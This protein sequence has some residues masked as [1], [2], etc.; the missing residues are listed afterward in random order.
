MGYRSEVVLALSKE[1]YM[2]YAVL[3][4]TLP[5]LLLRE[6][7]TVIESRGYYWKF[8]GIKWYDTYPRVIE[9]DEFFDKLEIEK[10]YAFVRIGEEITDIEEKGDCYHFDI[11]PRAS[12]DSPL[13]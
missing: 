13:D 11:Y 1:V 9:V 6:A 2:E 7:P 4:K 5:K 10:D 12:I 8:G 3:S